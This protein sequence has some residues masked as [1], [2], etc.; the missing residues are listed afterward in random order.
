MATT[1]D[2]KESKEHGK[3]SSSGKSNDQLK[4]VVHDASKLVEDSKVTLENAMDSARK[5]AEEYVETKRI[6]FERYANRG[7]ETAQKRLIEAVD[8]SLKKLSKLFEQSVT[9]GRDVLQR[10]LSKIDERPAIPVL[11]ALAG[12]AML[13]IFM[14]NRAQ[15]TQSKMRSNKSGNAKTAA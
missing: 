1:N 15:M 6:E 7:L 8:V 9:N 10:N 3:K 14:S 4:E 11:L 12:G 2:N 13:G 5:L